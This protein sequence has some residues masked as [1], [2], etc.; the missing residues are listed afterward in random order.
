MIRLIIRVIRYRIATTQTPPARGRPAREFLS[1]ARQGS[2]PVIL[3]QHSETRLRATR[4]QA[5]VSEP[6]DSTEFSTQSPIVAPAL[7]RLSDRKQNPNR[8]LFLTA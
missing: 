2:A 7:P 3:D 8:F 4:P 1:G 5:Q 6:P